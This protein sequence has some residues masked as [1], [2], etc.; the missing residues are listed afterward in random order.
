MIKTNSINLSP[1]YTIASGTY[2]AYANNIEKVKYTDLHA[3]LKKILSV[4][5]TSG[6]LT[7]TLPVG[8]YKNSSVSSVK[9]GVAINGNTPTFTGIEGKDF[10]TFKGNGSVFSIAGVTISLPLSSIAQTAGEVTS[11]DFVIHNTSGT[12]LVASFASV[13]TVSTLPTMS[14]AAITP[15]PDPDPDPVFDIEICGYLDCYSTG[16]CRP[17]DNELSFF[18][19]GVVA[20]AGYDGAMIFG[21]GYVS[22]STTAY[23]DGLDEWGGG[24]NL[25]FQVQKAKAAGFT[26]RFLSFG[27]SANSFIANTAIPN[28]DALKT[29]AQSMA[30]LAVTNDL[31]GIDFDFEF[32]VMGWNGNTNTPSIYLPTSG[33]YMSSTGNI[34]PAKNFVNEL[35]Y[36]IKH[37][38][39]IALQNIPGTPLGT[40]FYVA[41]APQVNK[42]IQNNYPSIFVSAVWDTI[43]D[44]GLKNG[45]FDYVFIQY[46]NTPPES[47]LTYAQTSWS[48]LVSVLSPSDTKTKYIVGYPSTCG[49]AVGWPREKDQQGKENAN[50]IYCYNS[51][52]PNVGSQTTTLTTAAGVLSLTNTL[53]EM[54]NNPGTYPHFGGVFCWSLNRDFSNYFWTTP[55]SINPQTTPITMQEPVE[56]WTTPGQWGR[57]MKAILKP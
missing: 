16:T 22:N 5:Q 44:L 41:C 47:N 13:A 26:K 40:T 2:V 35:A 12:A 28:E 19:N 31:N 29:L 55:A 32:N 33:P 45:N 24:T 52:T 30:N 4:A 25:K 53:Q 49:A 14:L 21:F 46:Y 15:A 3:D 56:P 1:P 37:Y 27:G 7:C 34:L 9:V 11:L 48:D 51:A 39:E 36:W 10:V 6:Y 54:A 17:I 38:G 43:F 18:A 50:N 57:S 20:N 8:M 23:L 42:D